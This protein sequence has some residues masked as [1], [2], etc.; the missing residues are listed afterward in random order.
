MLDAIHLERFWAKV[1]KHPGGCWEWTGGRQGNGYGSFRVAGR[2]H[3]AHRISWVLARGAVPD[4]LMLCH[5]CNWKRCVN[6][7]HLRAGTALDNAE[8]EV[9]R[10][11]EERMAQRHAG[12]I[13]G[14]PHAPARNRTWNLPIK[15]RLL[16][17]LS[18]RCGGAA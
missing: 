15:S 18:Y 17:Q 9:W 16:C 6:P 11:Y 2:S 1:R 7:D 12:N 3:T 4:G 13:A 8:D 10:R 5:S 14:Y